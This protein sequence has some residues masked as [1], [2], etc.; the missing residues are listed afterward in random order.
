VIKNDLK[1]ELG[2]SLAELGWLD[3]A[4]LLPYAASQML[5]G[6][7][8]DKMS[9]G[10]V[11]G[12]CMVIAAI[13]MVS[14]GQWRSLPIFLFLLFINGSAQSLAWPG[15]VKGVVSWFPGE[16]KNTVLGL[17]GTSAFAGG[18]L[19]TFVAVSQSGYES[20]SIVFG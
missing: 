15:A 14:F 9:P 8:G 2:F 11:M 10:K 3:T 7:L 4:F 20:A 6:S 5:L 17:L 18:F 13:S 16:E 19:G 12:S 1:T